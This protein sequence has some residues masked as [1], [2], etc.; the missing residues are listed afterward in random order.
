MSEGFSLMT[1]SFLGFVISDCVWW[2]YELLDSSFSGFSYFL[3]CFRWEQRRRQGVIWGKFPS[4][5]CFLP[6]NKSRRVIWG[7]FPSF[8]SFFLF[9]LGCYLGLETKKTGS[10]L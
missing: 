8:G 7:K 6:W 5:G 2:M 3:G 4:F 1:S 9:F 10:N